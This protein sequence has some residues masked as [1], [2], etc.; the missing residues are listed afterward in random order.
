MTI[1]KI[2]HQL[3]IGPKP[4]P[5]NHMDTWKQM[6]PDFEYIRWDERLIQSKI[7]LECKHRIAEMKEINGQAD[8]IRWEILYEYGGVFLDADSICVDK[9]DDVLMNCKCF[10]GWEHETLRKGLIATGTM[11]FPPKH[12]PSERSH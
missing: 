10:A 9:I 4:P 2:I 5:S 3:W 7:T 12:P 11:G 8:I 6:N 1:P